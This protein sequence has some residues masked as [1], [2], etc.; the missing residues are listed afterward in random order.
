MSERVA[1]LFVEIG[2]KVDDALRGMQRVKEEF[3]KTG[4]EA[5]GL[6]EA[7]SSFASVAAKA[8]AVVS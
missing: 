5:G 7:F 4:E 1:S 6:G 8:V 3:A 2:A